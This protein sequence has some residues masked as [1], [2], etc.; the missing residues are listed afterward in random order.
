MAQKMRKYLQRDDGVIF[1][2]NED[3]AMRKNMREV[4]LD[5]DTFTKHEQ[6]HPPHPEQVMQEGFLSNLSLQDIEKLG[7]IFTAMQGG[8]NPAQALVTA[9]RIGETDGKQAE[10]PEQI[11]QAV[12]EQVAQ[13]ETLKGDE[14]KSRPESESQVMNDIMA[15]LNRA[16]KG[17]GDVPLVRSISKLVGYEVTAAERDKALSLMTPA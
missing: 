4:E 13:E 12:A 1:G 16:D 7:A 14:P 15:V 11:V 3:L 2:W 9:K 5:P 17:N 10:G 8:A 6:A